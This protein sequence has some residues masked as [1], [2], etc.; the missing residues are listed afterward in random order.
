MA[1]Y[2]SS[3]K[4]INDRKHGLQMHVISHIDGAVEYAY[5]LWC[6]GNDIT[7]EVEQLT[8]NFPMVNEEDRMLIK[9]TWNIDIAEDFI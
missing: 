7:A 1:G 6:N 8:E 5:T 3:S 4:V 9:I 2:Y